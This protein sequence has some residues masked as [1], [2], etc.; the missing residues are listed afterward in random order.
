MLQ[1]HKRKHRIVSYAVS[2]YIHLMVQSYSL[3]IQLKEM[4][5]KVV[6]VKRIGSCTVGNN[7]NVVG[8]HNAHFDD[9]MELSV[10]SGCV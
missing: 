6:L 7:D 2:S 8:T 1:I 5:S 4:P 10:T 3:A 9:T